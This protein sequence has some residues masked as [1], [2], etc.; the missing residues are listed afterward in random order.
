MIDERKGFHHF[1]VELVRHGDDGHF[2]DAG[3]FTE[4]AF[5]CWFRCVPITLH[6]FQSS[7]HR[8]TYLMGCDGL[9]GRI[10]Y[11]GFH[12]DLQARLVLADLHLKAREPDLAGEQCDAVLAVA[13]KTRGRF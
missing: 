6:D 10:D 8:F 9:A 5:N 2:F 4:G 11:V 7:Y 1:S 3:D 12:N 13:P